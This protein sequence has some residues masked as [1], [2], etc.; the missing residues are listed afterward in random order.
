[1]KAGGPPGVW[2]LDAKGSGLVFQPVQVVSMDDA[3]VHVAGLA[4]GSRVVSVGAQKLDAGLTVRAIE[5]TP[6]AA[7]ASA[8]APIAKSSP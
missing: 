1:V 2:V 8:T 6:E 5:R 7:H 3:S 4:A